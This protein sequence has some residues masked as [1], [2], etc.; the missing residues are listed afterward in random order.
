MGKIKKLC[1]LVRN[2][3]VRTTFHIARTKLF[4]TRKAQNRKLAGR[5]KLSMAGD[6]LSQECDTRFEY[7]PLI[8]ILIPLYNTDIGMLKC[9]IE[10]VVNQTYA[11]WE[12]CLCDASD[13]GHSQVHN[14]CMEY[15]GKDCRIRYKKLD[16][17][18]GIADNTNACADMAKGEYYGLLDHDDILHPSALFE[19]VNEINNSKADFIYTDEITFEGEIYNILSSNFKPDFSKDTL[20]ANNYICH[21]TVFSKALFDSAGGFRSEYD[22][23]QDHDLFLRLTGKA[24]KISHIPK[25]LYF[26]RAHKASV[27]SDIHAKEYA[28]DAG[29]RAVKDYLYSIGCKAEVVSTDIYPT[30]YKINYPLPENGRISIIIPNRNHVEDL[31]RCINSILKS[32]YSDYEII[33]VENNSTD[34]EIFDYYAELSKDGKI[35]VITHNI[36]FNYSELNNTAAAKATG[37]YLL[38]LNNDTEVINA[39]WLSEMLMFAARED[40]G[41]VGARLFYENNTLQHCYI[42]TGAGENRVAIHAGLGLAKDDYGYLDRI[43]F[44]QN[45]SAVTGA[46]LM[47]SREKFFAVNG[48]DEK[49]PVA[50]NDIDLC[51]KLRQKNWVNIYTPFATLYHYES[52]SRGKDVDARSIVR[53]EE[54]ARYMKDK[55]KD[56]LRDPYYNPNFSLDRQYI[57]E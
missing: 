37:D 57:L 53:L 6:K 34:K 56:G 43:G 50:Y 27:V 11:K 4:S 9:V 47:V 26:W 13:D 40:V 41:A 5:I 7:E 36:P 54:E 45:V 18:L 30:I 14:S 22:G 12:L 3:G 35:K 25:V 29:R 17:N 31:K 38:F 15:A 32:A 52:M 28:I 2:Y 16:T 46:C 55:W 42:I 48:F 21:F 10:S 24:V 39:D 19:V 20:R 23:S 44:N 33:I 1:T 51:L 49:L 8:S